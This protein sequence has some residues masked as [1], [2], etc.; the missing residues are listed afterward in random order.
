MEDRDNQNRRQNLRIR[1]LPE[2][3]Q[4]EDL[5]AIVEKVIGPLIEKTTDTFK[6]ERVHRIRKPKN[7][8]KD[9]PRDVIVRF[10]YYDDKAQIWE[11]ENNT[12]DTF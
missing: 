11:V 7:I 1:G 4:E 12:T 10:H 9:I 3:T 8:A 2:T 5:K 6:I